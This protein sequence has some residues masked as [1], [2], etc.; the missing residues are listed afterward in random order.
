MINVHKNKIKHIHKF[1]TGEL[2]HCN[3]L[4]YF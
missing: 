4:L 2:N 1:E 3:I